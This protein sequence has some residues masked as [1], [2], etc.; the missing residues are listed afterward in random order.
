MTILKNGT[1][2]GYV[3]RNGKEIRTADRI[4]HAVDGTIYTIDKFGRAKSALGFIYTL[5]GQLHAVSIPQPDGTYTYKL[6][7]WQLTDE[8]APKAPEGETVTPGDDAQ[9]FAPD[10][11]KD[12]RNEALKGKKKKKAEAQAVEN[13]LT[14]D[15]ARMA[16]AIQDFQDEELADE[17]RDRGYRGEIT[18]TKTI[19]I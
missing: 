15:Q 16:I 10:R 7:D 1:P 8:P 2:T 18:K 4:K 11:V 17:L 19:K 13:G 12:P 14:V 3:D 9:N 6:N 5:G